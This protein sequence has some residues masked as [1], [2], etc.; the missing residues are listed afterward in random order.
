[1]TDG[2]S[3]TINNLCDSAK[4]TFV[5]LDDYLP[6]TSGTR[7]PVSPW[8]LTVSEHPGLFHNVRIGE[9]STGIDYALALLFALTVFD[10]QLLSV[11]SI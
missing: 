1:M 8:T 9:L 2:D 6:L 7:V 3:M 11:N 10:N 5:T 4:G